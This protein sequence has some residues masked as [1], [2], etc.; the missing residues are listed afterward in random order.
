MKNFSST[1]RARGFLLLLVYAAFF[2]LTPVASDA[3]PKESKAEFPP[4]PPLGLDEVP[5][6]ENNPMTPAKVE[7]GR[8]LFFEKRISGDGTLSCAT[9]HNPKRGY[10]NAR[11]YGIGIGGRIG[12]RNVPTALNAAYSDTQF[13]DGRAKSLEEQAR[14]PILHPAEMGATETHVTRTL[15]ADPAYRAAFKKAFGAKKITF[16]L[17]VKAIATF[18]RTLLSGNSPFDRWFFGEEK[19]AISLAAQRGFGIFKA[20]GNCVKCHL[21][22]SFSAPL[23]DNKFHNVGVG[24]DAKPPHSGRQKVSGSTRDWGKFKTPTLR[25]I[26]KTGPYMHD[27][28]MNTL[29]EVIDYYDRGGLA[30][31]NIDPD[32]KLLKLT[33]R[34][35]GDL[36]AFLKS[37]DGD[38][39]LIK[40]PR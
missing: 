16:D 25:D 11:K 3:A 18:E 24:S 19:T 36:L 37:L 29:E 12:L 10:S 14:G 8:H 21:V 33:K 23:T 35:K 31:R 13:W 15:R 40:A 32:M 6:P 4:P 5:I 2:S 22:D 7:L 28:S 26:S 20:K 9:C 39:P 38:L 30:N 1:S 34:E 27:G 17:V